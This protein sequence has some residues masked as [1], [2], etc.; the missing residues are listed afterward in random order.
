[1]RDGFIG[2]LIICRI[3]EEEF[4]KLIDRELQ[5]SDLEFSADLSFFDKWKKLYYNSGLFNGQRLWEVYDEIDALIANLDSEITTYSRRKIQSN[6]NRSSQVFR[7]DISLFHDAL[8]ANSFTEYKAILNKANHKN[9]LQ[10]F[11]I[12]L[13]NL[14][15]LNSVLPFAKGFI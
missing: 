1:M 9:I 12:W 10:V 5:I 3:W 8:S 15:D 4:E 7:K 6:I 2:C 13:A 14:G 11:P